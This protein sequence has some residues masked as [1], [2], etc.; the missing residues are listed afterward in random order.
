[1]NKI[2]EN[3]FIPNV[4]FVFVEELGIKNGNR[5]LLAGSLLVSKY[6]ES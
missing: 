1:M 4:I 5:L 2:Q 3:L 6:W